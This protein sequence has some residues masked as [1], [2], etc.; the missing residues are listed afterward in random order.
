VL[1]GDIRSAD[2]V[3]VAF[4]LGR[5]AEQQRVALARALAAEADCLLLD[6]PLSNLDARLRTQMRDELRRLVK[7]L[8]AAMAAS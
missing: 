8:M 3:V 5:L 7:S 6:E 1:A 2:G 4:A